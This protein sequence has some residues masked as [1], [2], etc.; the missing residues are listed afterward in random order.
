MEPLTL[1]VI[2]LI[3][4]ILFFIGLLFAFYWMWH[5]SLIVKSR[6]TKS[7]KHPNLV[8]YLHKAEK[9]GLTKKQI[10]LEL[11]KQGWPEDIID[12]YL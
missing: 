1:K 2:V 4:V 9:Q 10:R 8:R 5:K 12:Q 3:L 6:R 7:H 11:K